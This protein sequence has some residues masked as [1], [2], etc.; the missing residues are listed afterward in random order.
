MNKTTAARVTYRQQVVLRQALASYKLAIETFE[1][2]GCTVP[3][4]VADWADQ[5][6]AT[7]VTVPVRCL[8]CNGSFSL[9]V[10]LGAHVSET[11]FCPS[12]VAE[13]EKLGDVA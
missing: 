2:A 9:T 1:K 13:I 8:A 10:P 11:A 6:A 3:S 7:V 4:D 12:C 5:L